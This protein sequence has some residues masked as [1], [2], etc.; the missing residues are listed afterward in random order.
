[1]TDSLTRYETTFESTKNLPMTIAIGHGENADLVA[2]FKDGGIDVDL[3]GYTARAIYQPSSKWGTDEWYECPCE[4]VNDTVIAHWGNTYDNGDN[5]VKLF[6]HLLKDGKV[7]Y[8]AIYQIRL[9]E[10]PGFAPNPITPIPETL[11]F[12]QYTLVN[13][14]WALQS[15]FNTLFGNVSTLSGNVNTLSGNV[16]T[17]T[18]NVSS[19]STRVNTVAANIQ[20]K[21]ESATG[22]ES[23]TPLQNR[24]V[25]G[26]ATPS[27]FSLTIPNTIVSPDG[28]IIYIIDLI[29]DVRNQNQATSDPESTITFT[30]VI[31]PNVHG[32]TEFEFA[33]DEGESF[34]DLMKV[35]AGKMAR[36]YFTQTGLY[37]NGKFLIHVSKKGIEAVNP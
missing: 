24:M 34:A 10:T 33:V 27:D 19:L 22:Y 37:H 11:D 18:G 8:P 5:A 2:S 28:L 17:L 32:E 4:I 29:V 21:Y 3:T 25:Y 12:S 14:P 9:F 1:M 35:E 15:D 6:M 7:A 23:D 13:A 31:E 26:I 30:P 20:Y 16:S 36:F